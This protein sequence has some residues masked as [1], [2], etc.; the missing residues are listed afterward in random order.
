MNLLN[1]I[2]MTP[3]GGGDAG[4]GL[5]STLIMFLLIILIFYFLII[6]PQQKRQKERQK[7]LD[8]IQK[9]DNVITVGGAHGKII[10]V[11]EKT[12][13]IQV[14]DNVK[15]KFEKSAV[16]T[17]VGKGEAEIPEKIG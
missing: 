16:T 15:I 5:F 1:F 7:M 2:A 13:L 12:Y 4:G 17:V 8:A 14:A 3:Q 9:G 6:R 10:G 11:D